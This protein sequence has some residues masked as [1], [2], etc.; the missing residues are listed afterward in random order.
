MT[1]RERNPVETRKGKVETP[2]STKKEPLKSPKRL[3]TKPYINRKGCGESLLV[4]LPE[5]GIKSGAKFSVK[6]RTI[7]LQ[8]LEIVGTLA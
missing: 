6:K 1:A 7:S 4:V 2:I 8:G 5:I 3:Y